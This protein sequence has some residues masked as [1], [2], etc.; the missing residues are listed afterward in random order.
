M[1]SPREIKRGYELGVFFAILGSGESSDSLSIVGESS[2]FLARFSIRPQAAPRII[3][4]TTA[5]MGPSNTTPKLALAMMAGLAI[6]LLGYAVQQ[7][8]FSIMAV[9]IF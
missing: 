9:L 1:D 4:N 8:R 7:T 6:H 3:Q 5:P 2:S